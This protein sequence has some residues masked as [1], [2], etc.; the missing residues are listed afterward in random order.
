MSEST[1][2]RAATPLGDG[3]IE[4]LAIYCSDGRFTGQC[5]QFIRAHLGIERCDQLVVPGGPAALIEPDARHA[6]FESAKFLIRAHD[7]PRV[8]L[9][10]H[11]DCGYYAHLREL[12]GDAQRRAQQAD[13][14]TI[15][16]RLRRINEDLAIDTYEARLDTDGQTVTFPAIHP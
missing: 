4:A 7:L 2:F 9:I 3:P 5:E 14:D 1:P 11:E 10:M 13:L 12:T 15:L 16:A 6:A 8:V